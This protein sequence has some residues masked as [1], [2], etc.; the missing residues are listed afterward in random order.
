M[1]EI[2]FEDPELARVIALESYRQLTKLELIA[3]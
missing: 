1:D 2:L 3:S